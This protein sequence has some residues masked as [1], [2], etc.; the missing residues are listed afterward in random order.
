MTSK[1]LKKLLLVLA[2]LAF[3]ISLHPTTAT[4]ASC[5]MTCWQQNCQPI[6]FDCIADGIDPAVCCRHGN[7]CNSLCGTDC[8]RFC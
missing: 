8:P 5:N 6:Y 7:A 3:S 2:I 1:A 4:S